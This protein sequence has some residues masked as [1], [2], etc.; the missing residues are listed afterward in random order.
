MQELVPS[1]DFA[2]L[3]LD[4]MFD[5]VDLID[6]SD[7]PG[8]GIAEAAAEIIEAYNTFVSRVE[9]LALHEVV[10]ARPL[11]DVCIHRF[12]APL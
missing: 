12:R 2:E 5:N 11:L 8:Y 3:R 4:G 6:S 7:V 9:Q 10:D 1:W